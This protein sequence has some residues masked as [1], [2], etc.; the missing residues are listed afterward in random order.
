M[1]NTRIWKEELGV[2]NEVMSAVHYFTAFL[3]PA[4]VIKRIKSWSMMSSHRNRLMKTLYYR[5]CCLQGIR[6]SLTCRWHGIRGMEMANNFT[7]RLRNRRSSETKRPILGD[8]WWP[9]RVREWTIGRWLEHGKWTP[10]DAKHNPFFTLSNWD[11]KD[12]TGALVGHDGSS[13]K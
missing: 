5:S 12:N 4:I 8:S 13:P 2:Y 1:Q 6:N 7:C 3:I 11:E 10:I 9:W